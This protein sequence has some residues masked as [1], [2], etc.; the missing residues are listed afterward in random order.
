MENSHARYFRDDLRAARAAVLADAEAYALPYHALERLGRFLY[1]KA[2]NLGAVA[3]YLEKLAD[4]SPLSRLGEQWPEFHHPFDALFA[5]ARHARNDVMHVGA[6]ARHL[7]T[8][9][10][11]ACLILEDALQKILNTV[12]DFMVPNPLYVETWHPLSMVR[13][14][15]LEHAFTNLPISS[16]L[17]D[18]D[19]HM[20]SDHQLAVFLGETDNRVERIA[21]SIDDARHMGLETTKAVIVDADT[22][23]SEALRRM[24]TQP[25][26]VGARGRVVGI[27]TAFDLL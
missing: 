9:A 10:I 27:V 15:M 4:D 26:L 22:P 8:H 17:P 2:K 6:K 13:Q 20:I 16:S 14:R 12:A 3:E 18:E 11:E 7:T 25:L 21:T 19:W 5:T 1:P 23:V 24:G